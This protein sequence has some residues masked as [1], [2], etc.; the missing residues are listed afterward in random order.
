MASPRRNLAVTTDGE[1]YNKLRRPD[2]YLTSTTPCLPPL[3]IQ[4]DASS[5]KRKRGRDSAPGN[6]RSKM[7]SNYHGAFEDG[8]HSRGLGSIKDCGM[9]TMLPGL[10]E[11]LPSDDPMGEAVAYLQSVR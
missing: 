2:D 6:K 1:T 9:R 4:F 10:D 11:E 3:P 7:S 5:S 8:D